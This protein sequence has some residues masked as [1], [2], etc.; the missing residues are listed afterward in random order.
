MSVVS[1]ES[2]ARVSSEFIVAVPG[3]SASC[4]STRSRR[5]QN[6]A[7]RLRSDVAA[8]SRGCSARMQASIDGA[9]ACTGD[10]LSCGL[11]ASVW[12]SPREEQ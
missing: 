5:H 10:A 8:V 4:L 3:L 9:M 12:R 1:G 6:E 7:T 11:R 2:L